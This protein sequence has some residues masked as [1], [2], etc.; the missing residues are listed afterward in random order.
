MVR[1][2]V[3]NF[4]SQFNAIAQGNEQVDVCS[5][6]CGNGTA[7]VGAEAVCFGAVVQGD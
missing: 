6:L 4:L 5:V 3:T 2:G 7:P 1:S